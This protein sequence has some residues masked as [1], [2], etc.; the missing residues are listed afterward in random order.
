[1]SSE[2]NAAQNIV[3]AHHHVWW[4]AETSWL[5]GPQVP[6]IFGEYDAIQRDY[7]GEEFAEDVRPAGVTKSVYVQINLPPTKAAWEVEAVSAAGARNG[8]I[9][10]VVAQADLRSP[11]LEQDLD[12]LRESPTVRGI[13]QQ[14]HWHHNPQYR[15][16][17]SPT[18]MLD[19]DWQRGLRVLASHGL[20]FEA[21]VFPH[22]MPDL[23]SVIDQY[24]DVQFVL[25]HAGMPEDRSER[26]M[27]FWR[28]QLARLA[29]RTNLAVK[30]SGL[31][32]FVRRCTVEDWKPVIEQTVDAFGP[33]RCM[34]G[35]NFPIE[36]LWTDYASLVHVFR[37][38]IAAYSPL[39]QSEILARTAERVYRV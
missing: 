8:L 27:E 32:T 38:C 19:P 23:L 25:L 33:Q 20:L 7:L 35:S 31:G 21:Q 29:E 37:E 2:S 36:K 11:N 34:F 1:V 26:A 24:P 5:Q 18:L 10:G 13:R 28:R 22:Q 30:L 4:L 15:F 9:Q 39:E 3:D 16:A 12:R 6:R 17:D 14:L